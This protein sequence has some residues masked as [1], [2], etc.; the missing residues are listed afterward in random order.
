V[1]GVA[2][3]TLF[4]NLS[5]TVADSRCAAAFRAASPGNHGEDLVTAAGGE[6]SSAFTAPSASDMIPPPR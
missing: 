2:E 6:L 3:G 1:L 4:D 5:W